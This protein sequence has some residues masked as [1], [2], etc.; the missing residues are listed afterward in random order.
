MV[1]GL[2]RGDNGG[3][4]AGREDGSGQAI[5]LGQRSDPHAPITGHARSPGPHTPYPPSVRYSPVTFRPLSLASASMPASAALHTPEPTGGTSLP[6][7][8]RCGRSPVPAQTLR[9]VTVPF[10]LPQADFVTSRVCHA[11]RPPS[12]PASATIALTRRWRRGG[13]TRFLACRSSRDAP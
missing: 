10:H 8:P 1:R 13:E 7:F 12:R 9:K 6:Y 2:P 3:E 4:E 5:Y 11:T